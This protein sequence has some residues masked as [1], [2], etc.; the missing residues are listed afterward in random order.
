MVPLNMYCTVCL[1]GLFLVAL[2]QFLL[3]CPTF[4]H[5]QHHSTRDKWQMSLWQHE[6][7]EWYPLLVIGA[8]RLWWSLHQSGRLDELRGYVL[9]ILYWVKWC[10]VLSCFANVCLNVPCLP[11]IPLSHF[12]RER[13]SVACITAGTGAGSGSEWRSASSLISI[14]MV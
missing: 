14:G 12:A 6:L 7:L 10:D 1:C 3:M 9:N 5:L 13:S 4:P 8:R 2:V 11:F